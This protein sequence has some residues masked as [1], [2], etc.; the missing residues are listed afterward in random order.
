MRSVD[1]VLPEG[2]D[3][4]ARRS[5]GNVYDR[6]V[7]DGLRVL[8]WHVREH[9]VSG[10]WPTPTPATR[11]GLA[12]VLARVDDGRVVVVDGLL[13][14]GAEDVLLAQSARLRLVVLVHLPTS[15]GS[16]PADTAPLEGAVL[17]SAAAVVTT[18]DW[19]RR[20]LLDRY[21]LD[22]GSV[23]VAVPG[24]DES[25]AV[26][27]T[28]SGTQLLCV[29]AVVPNKGQDVLLA[30]LRELRDLAWQCRCVGSTTRDPVFAAALTNGAKAAGLSDRFVLAGN[31]WAS[32]LDAA[33]AGA[34][35][36]VV[37][38]R[39]ETYGLV[40]TE[41]L[42]RGVPVI[43]SD[44][45]GVPEALGDSPVGRPGLLLP[46]GDVGAWSEALRCWLTDPEVRTVLRRSAQA[47][48]LTLRPWSATAGEVSLVLESVAV[49][50]GREPADP[51]ARD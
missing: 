25:D 32:E 7:C 34:D 13:S 47:R 24:V 22:E 30:A 19:T 14:S 39:L 41:A 44:V 15:W 21:E 49:G 3:D 17:R 10:A 48:R 50:L 37:P 9:E 38:S 5:G 43:A 40:V 33:Y 6:Y 18:S 8:G 4:V 36:L 20:W 12:G 27:G 31:R 1:V 23:H 16:G 46:P 35:V 26:M 42:A 28:E 11:E 51:V 2:V 45:G 29:A